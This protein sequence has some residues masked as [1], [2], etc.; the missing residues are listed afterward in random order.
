MRDQ[1]SA[2][3]VNLV[4]LD[5]P[6]DIYQ[7]VADRVTELLDTYPLITPE[8]PDNIPRTYWSN[9][10]VDRG[11]VKRAVM[12]VPYGVTMY[13]IR[14]Q[15]VTE[16]VKRKGQ[17]DW[18]PRC[19]FLAPIVVGAIGDVVSAA[20]TAM[21]WLKAVAEAAKDADANLTWTTPVGLPVVQDYRKTDGRQVEVYIG[22]QK[23]RV[24]VQ[25]SFD[26]PRRDFRKSISGISPNYIH[27][28]DAAHMMKTVN[29]TTC[30]SLAMVHDSYGTLACDVDELSVALRTAFI[31]LHAEPLMNQLY[32][33]LV[34]Q[35]INVPTPPETGTFDLRS[36]LEA[37]YFFA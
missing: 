18:M 32:D 15:L 14:D 24:R 21:E 17:D 22:A 2:E 8:D 10:G 16:M 25:L 13:G 5:K 23:K 12:T 31:E 1:G 11:L 28:L 9:Q 26:T 36:I 6:A 30:R 35:G 29:R 34:E 27:S 37:D 20:S 7:R 4:K 3:A 19:T 33:H